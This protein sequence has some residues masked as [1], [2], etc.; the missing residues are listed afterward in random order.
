MSY[1]ALYRKWRPLVFEDVVEQSHV[2]RTLKNTVKA[3]R[4]GHAYLFCGTRGT[5]KTSMAKIFARAINCLDP[6]D[7][8]PCNKCEI[9]RGILEDTV[10][11]VVEIDAASNNS[12][13][14]VREIREEVVYAPSQSRYKVYI[15]DEVHMLSSGAFNALLKTLEEPPSHVVFILATTDPH[16]LPA[17]ILSRCQRFDFKKITQ[18]SIAERIKYITAQSGLNIDEDAAQLIAKLAD[19]AMRDALSIL[20]QCIAVGGSE[21]THQSVLDIVGIVSDDFIADLVEDIKNCDVTALVKDVESLS[22]NGRDILKFASDLVIYFR[23]LL[24]CKLSDNPGSIIEYSKEYVERMIQQSKA[25]DKT[26]LIGI[27]TEL[28][29]MESQ[30]KY[31]LNQRVFLEVVLISISTGSY[32]QGEGNVA[33]M[34]RIANLEQSMRSGLV[35]TVNPG[36]AGAPFTI[37]G[38][39]VSNLDSAQPN[40]GGASLNVSSNLAANSN[41]AGNLNIASHSN[42]AGNTNIAGH[43]NAAGSTNIAASINVATGI[44]KSVANSQDKKAS[45]KKNKA[46][47]EELPEWPKVIEELRGFRRMSL[48]AYL[49]TAK[50][51]AW[52]DTTIMIIFPD[53]APSLKDNVSKADNAEVIETILGKLLG[54]AVRIKT[55]TQGDFDEISMQTAPKDKKEDE[56][57]LLK[58]SREIAD[59]ANV[60]LDIIEE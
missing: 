53:N 19:G 48:V 20:D 45:S 56:S 41:V 31:A 37:A 39:S 25:F 17:T 12:V 34:D 6:H 5:G 2:V 8:D 42:V 15:I 50:A 44:S 22:S 35:A 40:L 29:S 30:L 1:T 51:V 60:P 26:R 43:S 10:L 21:I 7:G 4:I 14:N 46:E 28:S 38:Q 47:I 33:L 27:I 11:D 23:N 36:L 59:R 24:I 16:K 54:R 3:D 52:D 9:C 32:G 13:D 18:D 55:I 57:Q 58:Y 49:A